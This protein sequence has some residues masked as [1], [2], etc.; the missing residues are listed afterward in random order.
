MHSFGGLAISL[1]L[2]GIPHSHKMKLVLIAPAT[3]T[4]TAVDLLFRI[5]KLNGSVR[6]EFDSIIVEA[7]GKPV[8]WYSV[9]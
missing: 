3:E 6:K 2:E 8:S 5:L 1:A 4:S 7:G 9:S